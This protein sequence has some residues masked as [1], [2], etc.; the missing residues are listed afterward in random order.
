MDKANKSTYIVAA[1]A[2]I[3]ILGAIYFLFIFNKKPKQIRSQDVQSEIK[4]VDDVD[5]AK[6]PYLTLTPTTDGAEVII[7]MENMGEFDKIEYELTYLADNPQI[8]G[9]KIQRGSTG[10]DI[11]TKSPQ[12]KKSILLGTASKGV[13]SP[14]KNV[15]DGKLTLHM[16][17]GGIEYQSETPWLLKKEGA[18]ADIITDPSGKFKFNIPNMG[19]DYWMILTETVGIPPNYKDFKPQDVVL[20]I[21]AIFTI[22]PKF[23]KAADFTVTAGQ[24]L[25]SPVVYKYDRSD[26]SWLKLQSSYDQSTK[27]IKASTDST[28]SYTIVSP[29]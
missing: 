7:S 15:S 5:I 1:A 11:D 9:E 23:T 2:L 27:T 26:N 17:K 3:I 13:R 25:K 12:Y 28:G 21:N 10:T 4:K 20:P 6:R 24:D 19:K 14:D 18:T 22:G 8:A 16:F 29:K